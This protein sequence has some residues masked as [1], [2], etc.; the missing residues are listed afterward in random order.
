[1]RNKSKLPEIDAVE[2]KPILGLRPGVY[3]LIAFAIVLAL[4]FF[5]LF[6]LP[7]LLSDKA[8]VSFKLNAKNVAIYD[9]D[10]YLGSS[11]GSVYQ[12]EKGVHRFSFFV[13]GVS[14]GSIETKI[15]KNIFFSLFHRK[16]TQI[17]FTI[18]KNDEIEK[19]IVENFAKRV[20]KDS[21]VIDYSASYHFQPIFSEFASNAVS[22]SITDIKDV[23]LYG[24]LHI[25]SR[26]M[27]EDYIE[28]SNMLKNSDADF[29]SK[30]LVQLNSY[31]EKIF[32]DG[33]KNETIALSGNKEI[34]KPEKDGEMFIYPQS[35]IVIGNDAHLSYPDVNE[36]PVEASVDSF[37]ISAKLVSEYMYALFVAENPYWSKEN[38]EDLIADGMV[39]EN[40]LNGITLSTLIASSKPIR[41]VSYYASEAYVKW[42]SKSTSID[43]SLPSEKEWY[44]AALSAKNKVFASSLISMDT[45]D[46]TPSNLMGQLWEFTS[47]SYIPLGRLI[48]QDVVSRLSSMFDYDDDIVKG[49]SY[50]NKNDGIT[51]DS[52][53][54]VEK[55]T[56]SDFI[57]FRTVRH[58]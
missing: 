9:N 23:W 28:A 37:A 5:A 53:G 31:L 58:E 43:Y 46:T 27:Y 13:N 12:I 45:D 51:L 22:L 20:A 32:G 55:N 38:K 40:Y 35:T 49:G 36:A 33:N 19:S 47:T 4:L 41:A 57:G 54:V 11:E 44:V 8:Y 16:I 21:R 26:V 52:V 24:A 2:L 48:D 50:I 56:C 18:A 29:S 39:D 10:K 42:L 25:S 6:V 7:G 34:S 14:A 1:M 15:E 30:D 17:D 3:L